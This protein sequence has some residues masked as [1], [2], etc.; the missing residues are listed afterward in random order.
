MFSVTECTV[1]PVNVLLS[2]TLKVINISD[3]VL[4]VSLFSF[5]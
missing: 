4:F 3:F 1:C 5:A 2:L